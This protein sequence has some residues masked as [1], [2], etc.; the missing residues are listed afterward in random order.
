MPTLSTLLTTLYRISNEYRDQLED[1]EGKAEQELSS[2]L[3]DA[4]GKT[5]RAIERQL[6]R[7]ELT[8]EQS[9][10]M[11]S[12]I[13]RMLRRDMV[14]Q[15]LSWVDDNFAMAYRNGGAFVR[16]SYLAGEELGRGAQALRL[17]DDDAV[18]SAL[19][20]F[21]EADS[22]I[23]SSETQRGYTL[24]RGIEQDLTQHL[25]ETFV[26]HVALGSDTNTIA[27]AIMEGGHLKPI[28]GRTIEMRAQMISRTELARI[29]EEASMIKSR[30]VGIEHFRWDATFDS[31][32]GKDSIMRHGRIKTRQEWDKY[33]PDRFSGRPPLRPRDRC[34]MV[35]MSRKWI[36]DEAGRNSFD[37]AIRDDLRMLV[38]P[39]ER[40]FIAEMAAG[41]KEGKPK[42]P[43]DF[44]N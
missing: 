3:L 9:I 42:I 8:V 11:V 43:L 33:H 31:R 27:D 30:E 16:D 19:I 21:T 22:A 26:R 35:P 5:V 41:I 14:G 40:E 18:R 24:I 38:G 4:E 39:G 23:F 1:L 20:N 32:T 10:S 34:R 13:Q 6:R 29:D 44:L 25:R 36:K 17:I 15:G 12:E 28:G 37:H 2:I 7:G